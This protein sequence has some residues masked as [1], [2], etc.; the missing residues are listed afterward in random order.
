[1]RLPKAVV[2]LF[3]L[4]IT[5]CARTTAEVPAETRAPGASATLEPQPTVPAVPE[6]SVPE[7]SR[8]IYQRAGGFAGLDETWTISLDGRV[9]QPDGTILEVD[10]VRA[11]GLFE[12]VLRT[13]FF[14]LADSYVTPDTC[15][16]RFIH[17]ITVHMHDQAKTV[18]TIDEAPVQ[19]ESLTILLNRIHAILNTTG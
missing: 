8:L 11:K 13:D 18:S 10:S 17:T 6:V 3:I 14:A 4:L 19:P 1:M 15:C 7:D 16:D 9:E 5:S 2:P 12:Q